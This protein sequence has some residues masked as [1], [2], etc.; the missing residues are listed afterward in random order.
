MKKESLVVMRD[1][2]KLLGGRYA[3]P[4]QEQIAMVSLIFILI[5]MVFAY[6]MPAFWPYS[7]EQQIK[8]SENLKPF[9][10]SQTEQ[11]QID[12]G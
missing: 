7:Y 5:I 8:Y 10:Y 2:V 4:A 12:A 1:S 3:P 6:V 9:E 11:A